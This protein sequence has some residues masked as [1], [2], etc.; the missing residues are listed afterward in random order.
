MAFPIEVYITQALHGLVYAMLIFLVASGLTL[1]LGLMGVL[2]IAHASFYML[3][4]YFGYT[5]TAYSGS[6]WLGLICSP[7]I[8]GALGILT[9][10]FLLRKTY[11]VGHESQ[12]LLTFG[13]FFILGEIARM[14]WGTVPLSVPAP[15]V[16][17]GS[18]PLVGR[19]YPVYRLFILGFSFAVLLCMALMLS[20]TRVGIIIRAAVSDAKM[21]EALG[22]NVPAVFLGVFGGGS[23]LAAIAGVIAAP[24][25]GISLTMGGEALMDCFTVIVI[26]GFGSL[27]GAFI[28]CLVIGELHSFGILW[29]PELALVL[30]FLLMAGVLIVRPSGLLGEK[31]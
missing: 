31:E 24:F 23:A 16:L 3:G 29:V 7:L 18:I 17:S 13:L 14:I 8:V 28:A 30:Q 1:V 10:R 4:A 22:N 27:L 15:P 2:N 19:S 11:R 21:V 9:E 12:L 5:V 6:F 26:G 20:R 25:L